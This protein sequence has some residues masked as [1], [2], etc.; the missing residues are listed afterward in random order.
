MS[1]IAK[2]NNILLLVDLGSGSLT[3]FKKL[4]LPM[5]KIVSYY[6]K[7]GADIIT[8]SGDKLLGGPQAGIIAGKRKLIDK[9]YQNPFYRAF[10]YDKIRLS[11]MET[12]LRTY[13]SSDNISEKNL[14]INLFK[15]SLSKLKNL[16]EERLHKVEADISSDFQIKLN[17]SQVEAGSGSLPTEKITSYAIIIHSKKNKSQEIYKR[18]LNAKYSTIG[19]IKDDKYVIDLKAIPQDQIQ[20]LIYSI[21]EC[22]Q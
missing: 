1:K 3:D 4:G 9:M 8:F 14:T 7:A 22:L 6:L 15:R 21:K 17:K 10:R 13:Y 16:G 12:I 2:K 18:F 20:N 11:I 19:Y 5:E